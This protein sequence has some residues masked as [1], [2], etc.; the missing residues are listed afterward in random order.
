M[1]HYPDHNPDP[2][3]GSSNPKAEEALRRLVSEARNASSLE[4]RILV[5][6][7]PVDAQTIVDTLFPR[8]APARRD[9]IEGVIAQRTYTVAMVLEGLEDSGNVSAIMRTS[10]ALGFQ[11]FHVVHTGKRF[12]QSK[13]TTQGAEKWLDLWSWE[14]IDDCV[15]HLRREGRRIVVTCLEPGAIP[16]ADVD[17]T[18]PTALVFGNEGYGVSEAMLEAADVRCYLPM[19]GFSRSFN[20]SVAAGMCLHQ[21]YQ[22]RVRRLGAQGDL[23]AERRLILKA[24]LCLRSVGASALDALAQAL[25]EGKQ[26]AE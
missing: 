9:R 25:A 22:D 7:Q 17:F 23:D 14:T 12:R 20:A 5:G 19:V 3:P 4:R 1:R 21:A 16:L 26:G 6:E 15:T 18:Q 24:E 13:R 2:K 10:E 8:L 11:P